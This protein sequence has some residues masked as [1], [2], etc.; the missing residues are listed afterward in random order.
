VG[1]KLHVA[2]NTLTL[3][4]NG[5]I[6]FKIILIVIVNLQTQYTLLLGKT[7]Q[8]KEENSNITAQYL[9]TVQYDS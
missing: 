4:V 6:F 1:N 2:P 7:K 9:L 5:T 3:T 8:N